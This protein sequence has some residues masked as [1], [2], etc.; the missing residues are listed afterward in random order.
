MYVSRSDLAGYRLPGFHGIGELPSDK[1]ATLSAKYNVLRTMIFIENAKS[2]HPVDATSLS[3]AVAHMDSV[4]NQVLAGNYA[5]AATLE[6]TARGVLTMVGWSSPTVTMQDLLK[7]LLDVPSQI[8]TAAIETARAGGEVIKATGVD[9]GGTLKAI[10]L[11]LGIVGGIVLAV[12]L[13]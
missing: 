2:S 6:K 8:K 1:L 13:L 10:G 12:K 5:K 4:Y 7:A 11:G 9:T 3:N